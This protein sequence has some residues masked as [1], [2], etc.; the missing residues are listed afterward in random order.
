MKQIEHQA[1]T[2]FHNIVRKGFSEEASLGAGMASGEKGHVRCWEGV[3]CMDQRREG[4]NSYL[5]K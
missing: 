3:P 5:S 1:Q 4:A 2:Y